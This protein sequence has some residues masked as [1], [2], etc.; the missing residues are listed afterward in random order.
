MT[1]RNDATRIRIATKDKRRP[2][3]VVARQ[4]QVLL[5]TD[6]DQQAR[7]QLDRIELETVDTLGSPGR[8]LVPAGN[9]GFKATPDGSLATNVNIAAGWGYLDGW[10]LENPTACKL[11]TQPH[12]RTGDAFAEPVVVGIKALVRHVDP[13]EDPVLADVAL[14]DAQASGRSLADWQVFPLS[15][16]GASVTCSTV[17]ANATWQALVAPSTGTLTVIE[18][19][20]PP[21]TDPCSL[22]PDGGYTRLELWLHRMAR[23]VEGR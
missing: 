9:D 1:I 3:A 20:S 12:P 2:R 8:L 4:G 7:H 15:L 11:D 19:T 23:E 16:S 21:S 18:Q 6:F 10:R 17:A 14:G 22:T 5:D 13:V